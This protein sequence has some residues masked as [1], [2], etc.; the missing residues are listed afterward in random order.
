MDRVFGD[1]LSPLLGPAESRRF[2]VPAAG[3]I[4][5]SLDVHDTDNAYVVTAE[6]PGLEQ[7][8][9][10]LSLRDNVLAI[11]GEKRE[12]RR[13]ENAGRTYTERSY[14]RFQRSIPFDTE[15]DADK[16]EA[17]FKNGILTVTL[18]K[19]QRAAEKSRRI[20]VKSAP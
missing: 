7:K 20:E 6:L 19:S 17:S 2:G 1:F 9:V 10:E 11:S 15:I 4:W 3:G 14:G 13:D 5:P 12:E 16:V 8:D 18:P